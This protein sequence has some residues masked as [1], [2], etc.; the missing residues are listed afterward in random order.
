MPVLIGP[1]RLVIL[2]ELVELTGWHRDYARAVLR[3]ALKLKLVRARPPR[4]PIYGVLII[5]ALTTCWV[6]AITPELA[7]IADTGS[8]VMLSL[9]GQKSG[10][11][12]SSF[13]RLF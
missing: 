11:P 7:T 10:A 1:P 6:V 3:D 4:P 5:E 13:E 2:D 8:S 12:L 9:R